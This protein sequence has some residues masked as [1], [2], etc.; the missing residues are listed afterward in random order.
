MPA[1]TSIAKITRP[2]LADIYQRRRLFRLLD[3]GRKRPV[4]WVSG[5]AGYGKTTIVASWIEGRKLPCLW[6]QID[7][8]D[9]D[10]ATFFYY[11]GLAGK[12]AAP[13]HKKPMPLLTP[14]YL[15]DIS[16]FSK[17]YFEN[18]CSRL[19]TPFI[20]VFDNYQLIPASSPFHEILQAGLSA[21]PYGI[22]VVIISR[23]EPPAAFTRMLAGNA[24]NVIRWDDLRLTT[25]ESKGIALRL[26]KTRQH[27]DLIS[28]MHE[29]TDGWAAGL[30]LFIKALGRDAV[31]PHSLPALPPEKIFE[32][33]ANE[34]FQK[35]DGGTQEFLLKTSMLPKMTPPIAEQLTGNS[36]ADEILAQLNTRNYFTEKHTQGGLTYQ[37]HPLFREFLQTRASKV[38]SQQDI[39]RIKLVGAT[40]MEESGQIEDAA[41]LYVQA[42]ESD[43]LVRLIMGHAKSV[44]EQGRSKTVEEWI[45]AISGNVIANSPW[46][47]YWLGICRLPFDPKE[48]QK[49]FEEAFRRFEIQKDEPGI[50]L[51]WTGMAESIWFSFENMTQMDHWIPE[52]SRV[53][54]EFR[55]FPS[56]EIEAQVSSVMLKLLIAREMKHSEFDEWKNRALSLGDVNTRIDALTNLTAYHVFLGDIAKAA[57]TLHSLRDLLRTAQVSSLQHI[58]AKLHESLFRFFEGSCERGLEIATDALE[59]ADRTGI[60]VLDIMLVGNGIV[61]AFNFGKKDALNTLFARLP[62]H[63]EGLRTWDKCFYHFLKTA[64]AM[65]DRDFSSALMHAEESV[66]YAD[67]VQFPFSCVW[68]RFIY[69]LVLWELGNCERADRLLDEGYRI[70]HRSGLDVALIEYYFIK[71]Y[72]SQSR[73]QESSS[74]EHLKEALRRGKEKGLMAT[75]LPIRPAIMANLYMK[76]LEY[77]IEVEYVR[78]LIR[79]K[80]YIPDVSHLSLD[81]WPWPLKVYSFGE[82]KLLREDKPIRFSR[83]APKKPLEL[84]RV[85]VALG[86]KNLSEER[87]M[88]ALWPDAEGDGGRKAL[89]VTVSRLRELLGVKDALLWS[90]GMI[91]LN[92]RVIWTDV[93]AFE[94]LLESSGFRVRSSEVRGVKDKSANS[95][96]HSEIDNLQKALDFYRGHFLEGETNS[97]AISPRERHRESFLYAIEALGKHWEKSQEWHKAIEVYRKGVQVDDLFEKC[98]VRIMS[99]L[100]KLGSRAEALSVYRRLK[101]TLH[102]YGVEPSGEADEL[103]RQIVS[104]NNRH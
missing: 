55:N 90:E 6:Y 60:H 87:L 79:K 78:K 52:L 102:G 16:T 42:G 99:C 28:L 64:Q 91:S 75:Y 80:S 24:V 56:R 65:D 98:Y 35:I 82:F 10:M 29:K 12:K 37:Y 49:H 40:L 89:S 26:D 1:Q 93:W 94:R 95:N 71:A 84:L 38:F 14:E 85:I 86:G 61:I 59:M 92:D 5:P 2:A 39:S 34:L 31:E 70:L 83:K 13:R 103:H 17:R 53:K 33:F 96:P 58:A 76:A 15:L 4:T 23:T 69:A 27:K 88:D 3:A 77:G 97:W 54:K 11:L 48:S 74:V 18:L 51:S 101:K 20:L 44:I 67:Q 62:A 104:N 41:Q 22:H 45:R 47:L 81:N 25:E 73:G 66:K 30:I 21:I 7:E 50:F 100:L 72:F 8:G 57:N 19:K 32:Y 46:L 36:N 9:G 43:G 68:C 63:A